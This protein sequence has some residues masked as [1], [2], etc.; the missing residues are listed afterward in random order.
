MVWLIGL[1]ALYSG[2]LDSSPN[3]IKLYTSDLT[4]STCIYT[5]VI[6]FLDRSREIQSKTDSLQIFYEM[7][8]KNCFLVTVFL[9]QG[10]AATG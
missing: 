10:L 7:E 3:W 5:S 2:G 6:C 4:I 9:T 8:R 1:L